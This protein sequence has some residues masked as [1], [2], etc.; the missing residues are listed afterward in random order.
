MGAAWAL[1]K[2]VF[3]M[4]IPDMDR[5]EQVAM[6]G[7]RS[8]VIDADGLDELRDRLAYV[9]PSAAK[10]T[11]RWT[12]R[13]DRFLREFRRKLDEEVLRLGEQ[14]IP[15]QLPKEGQGTVIEYAG[16]LQ[17]AQQDPLSAVQAQLRKLTSVEVRCLFALVT[18][19]EWVL[20][21]L[22]YG[23]LGARLEEAVSRGTVELVRTEEDMSGH[24]MAWSYTAREDHDVIDAACD[25]LFA[26]DSFLDEHGATFGAGLMS[27]RP[28]D[29]TDLKYWEEV[30][31]GKEL[32]A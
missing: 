9:F 16:D 19:K 12:S 2:E 4:A 6:L 24:T 3:P 14:L 5:D 11:R 1:G 29:T 10:R 25:A 31:Y 32:P 20:G 13:R 22:D 15:P 23:P 30:L 17:E 26:L 8:A 21:F 7:R 27:D 28:A 18:G